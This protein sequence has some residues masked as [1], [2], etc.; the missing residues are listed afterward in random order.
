M[1]EQL[2]QNPGYYASA[3]GGKLKFSELKGR[4]LAEGKSCQADFNQQVIDRGPIP[5]EVLERLIF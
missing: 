2:Q 4:C 3:L 1:I 5:F